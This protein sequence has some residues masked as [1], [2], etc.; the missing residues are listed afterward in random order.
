MVAT[1]VPARRSAKSTSAP[2]LTVSTHIVNV[3]SSLRTH[4]LCRSG[5]RLGPSGTVLIAEV[6]AQPRPS[7]VR[8]I[9]KNLWINRRENDLR[10]GKDWRWRRHQMFCVYICESKRGSAFL[11][12]LGCNWPF[13]ARK[14]RK[15]N[16][17]LSVKIQGVFKVLLFF[18]Y[19]CFLCWPACQSSWPLED[20]SNLVILPKW[21]YCNY[22]ASAAR[23]SVRWP[24]VIHHRKTGVGV[25]GILTDG[26]NT[27]REKIRWPLPR[28]RENGRWEA[29]RVMGH[30]LFGSDGA[31]PDR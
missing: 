17:C 1:A 16:P 19:L 24:V 27:N 8:L 22:V 23:L 25:G 30:G 26:E 6:F 14:E 7:P 18:R 11:K 28:N 20:W 29:F 21:G 4:S 12:Y 2:L 31:R 3:T 5:V 13:K 15:K 9:V 10:K